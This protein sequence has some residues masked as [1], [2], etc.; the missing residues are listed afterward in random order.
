MFEALDASL[1]M[2]YT[3]TYFLKKAASGFGGADGLYDFSVY[4]AVIRDEPINYEKI[5]ML[6]SRLSA[7]ALLTD[8]QQRAF[9]AFGQKNLQKMLY[10]FLEKN[11]LEG[12]AQMTRLG[13][14][15]AENVDGIIESCSKS[16]NLQALALIMDYKNSRLG[17][18]EFDFT[19]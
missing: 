16:G 11:D 7:P 5:R 3:S 1:Y 2:P 9:F 19:I 18:T 15:T 10:Y 8:E 13:F 14:V 6:L 12:F 4:D 17:V